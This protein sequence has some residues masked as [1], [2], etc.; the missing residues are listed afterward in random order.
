MK[1]PF[2]SKYEWQHYS[3]MGHPARALNTT[4]QCG[5][6]KQLLFPQCGGSTCALTC[7]GTV[8]KQT[9]LIKDKHFGRVGKVL[10]GDERIS[11]SK[12]AY[13]S[14]DSGNCT[15]MRHAGGQCL[16]LCFGRLQ[17][18]DTNTRDMLPPSSI[19]R[20]RFKLLHS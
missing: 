7:T 3:M 9:I 12:L 5:G 8:N 19:S 4:E 6:G 13:F 11:A 10:R 20:G 18:P 17:K 15:S 14:F 1:I 16:Q 2:Y